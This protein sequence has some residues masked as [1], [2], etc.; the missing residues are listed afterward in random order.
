MGKGSQGFFPALLRQTGGPA[1]SEHQSSG[2]E[3]GE[4]VLNVGPAESG[5]WQGAGFAEDLWELGG[6]FH[7]PGP[8]IGDGLAVGRIGQIVDD[9]AEVWR[10]VGNLVE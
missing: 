4:S 10:C 9:D 8:F 6:Y 3:D 7:S 1:G 5:G 2:A